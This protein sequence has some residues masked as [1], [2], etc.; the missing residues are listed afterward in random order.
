MDIPGFPDL[1]T[2]AKINIR[3]NCT[4]KNALN[5][6]LAIDQLSAER[7]LSRYSSS[8]MQSKIRYSVITD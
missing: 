6:G 3:G 5:V 2:D 7:E 4:N 1:W 8:S